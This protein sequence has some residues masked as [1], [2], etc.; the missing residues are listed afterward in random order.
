MQ[1]DEFNA[2]AKQGF[3]RIPLVKEVLA[4]LETPLS[5]Y[6]KL[7]QAFGK[8]NTYLLESVVGGERFGRFSFIG[9][10]A[11]TLLRTAGTPT[12]PLTEILTDG[13][14]VESNRDNPLDF[15]DA[16]FKRF[17][18]PLQTGLPRFCGGLAGYFGYDTVRYIEAKLASHNLPD[19]LGV[20]DIQLMLTEELAV[21]DNVT[22]KIYFIVY[23]DPTEPNGFEKAQV[24]LKELLACL[25]KPFSMPISRPS[26][27]TDLVRNFKA[28]DFEKAVLKTKE[29][30]LA[31]DCMQVVIG[32]RISKPFTDSPLALYRALRSL[33]PSPYMYYYDF[34]DLQVVGS[35]PEILVRQELRGGEKMV[36]I[37]PL[38]GTRP[39]GSTPQEDERLAKE[40]L[41]DPKEIAEHVMLI[42]LARND[43]GRIA[44]TGSVQV[45]DSMSI[46]KYSHVQHIVSSVEGQLLDNMSNMDV[47]R[48]TF[49]AGTLSGA[50]KIRAMEIID[51]MEVV[52]RGVYGGAVGYL[53]FSGDMDVAIA[54]RTGVIRNGVLHS[55]AGAG[56]VAD[57]DPTAEWKETEA[58]A[59]AV[60]LAADLVQGGLD[61]PH[62]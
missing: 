25:S 61:A 42:D 5:L 14:V 1:L 44:K 49:P 24:R 59:R 53:S 40:L 8:K 57:S 33:N 60:L 3:N 43:V 19:E 47:L 21:I 34:G 52:K 54:I 31:G 13:K 17:K 23:A 18:V 50:P 46:E 27:K 6:V 55:Q 36:T 45:T 12:A 56:V 7:T 20:P 48:A 35:S 26:N 9:L 11:K 37:R 15:I 29:Y 32:Q 39:R 22:G 41:A 58:K 30:I 10:P 16:Y 4:D 38:A 62:D 28:A 2:L 51:E